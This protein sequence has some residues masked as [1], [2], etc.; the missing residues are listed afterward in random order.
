MRPMSVPLHAFLPDPSTGPQLLVLLG[1]KRVSHVADIAEY[2]YDVLLYC[3]LCLAAAEHSI[4]L[5]APGLTA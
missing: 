2:R 1:A 4:A 5:Q 3:C